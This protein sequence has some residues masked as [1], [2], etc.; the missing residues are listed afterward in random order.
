M[1]LF[2]ICSHFKTSCKSKISFIEHLLLYT[3]YNQQVFDIS[4]VI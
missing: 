2:Y 1:L 4:L 3:E